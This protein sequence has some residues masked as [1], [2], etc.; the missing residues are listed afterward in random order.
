MMRQKALATILLTIFLFS[1]EVQTQDSPERRGRGFAPDSLWDLLGAPRFKTL[2]GKIQVTVFLPNGS[3]SWT[4]EL[5][6]DEN[7][8]RGQVWLPHPEGP[9]QIVTF[10]LPEGFW[11]WLPFA[12]RAIR[13]EGGEFPSW[14]DMWQ[15][16]TDKLDMAKSNY[17]LRVVGRDRISGYFCLILQMEPKVKGN[18]TR[19]IWVH[20]PTRLPLQ[21][22][23]Y[24]PDGRLEI[25][26]TLT[27]AKINEP[28]PVMIL[29]PTVP[30]DWTVQ[31]LSMQRKKVSLGQADEVLGFTPVLPTWVPPGYLL[32]GIFAIGEHR[33]KMAHIVYTDG[34]GVISIFQ[35]P[36]PPKRRPPLRGSPFP[37]PPPRKPFGQ[38]PPGSPPPH[39][40]PPRGS[41]PFGGASPIQQMFPNRIA[42]R[43]VGNLTVILISEVSQDWLEKMA[44]SMSSAAR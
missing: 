16:R 40:S 22:E 11:V 26:V 41:P 19:K 15:I 27:E 42:F 24:S 17:N 18:A 6:A 2:Q 4:A 44:S 32:E 31:T 38:P 8:S 3:H 29:D 9:R 20:P 36:T 21:V 1:L 7:R 5:W 12:K 37:P 34:I 35:H 39:G 23:R 33:W 10:T 14:R 25:R 30:S 28:L 43:E 13:Y